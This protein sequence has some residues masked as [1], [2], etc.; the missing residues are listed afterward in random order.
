MQE[1][2]GTDVVGHEDTP[3]GDRDVAVHLAHWLGEGP[4]VREVHKGDVDRVEQTH[5]RREEDRQTQYVP[6]G[7][8]LGD[9]GPGEHEEGDL[10]EG[11]ESQPEDTSGVHLPWRVSNSSEATEESHLESP[12]VPMLLEFAVVEAPRAL[13][14]EQAHDAHQDNEIQDGD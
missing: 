3:S 9:A 8:A 10:G 7:R 14:D 13:L 6:E 12:S 5:P 2:E 4:T 11:V 1:L